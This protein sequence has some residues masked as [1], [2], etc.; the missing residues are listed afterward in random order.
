M[1]NVPPGSA[2]LAE[3]N[4]PQLPNG[5]FR[6]YWAQFQIMPNDGK[7]QNFLIPLPYNRPLGAV[8]TLLDIRMI[9]RVKIDYIVLSNLYDRLRVE[10]FHEN[11]AELYAETRRQVDM[12]KAIM[13]NH[14][15]IYEAVPVPG[16]I[17]G[18]HV[19]IYRVKPATGFQQNP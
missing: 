8:G 5:L 11:Q 15:L 2:L 14:E 10:Q 18:N 16:K 12:Y 13:D 9:N 3:S 4:T 7:F 17:T 19:R 6:Y 1:E